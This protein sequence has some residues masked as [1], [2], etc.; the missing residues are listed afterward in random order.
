MRELIFTKIFQRRFKRVIEKN[1]KLI[2]RIQ[3]TLQMLEE[4]PFQP[5]LETH[6]L[7]GKLEHRLAC[8]VSYDL[9][10]I[11]RFEERLSPEQDAIILLAIG[12]H[13]EVY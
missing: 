10:I 1:P 9:R 4:N 12:T 2:E 11:F 8:T 3:L 7:R 5:A 6:K 13:D